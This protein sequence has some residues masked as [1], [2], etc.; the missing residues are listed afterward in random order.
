MAT[1]RPDTALH[2]S[3]EQWVQVLRIDWLL[4]K[5]HQANP[6]RKPWCEIMVAIWGVITIAA[7]VRDLKS[8]SD[9]SANEYER[10]L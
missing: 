4:A 3:V 9:H 2:G 8:D 7:P 1:F 5:A 10:G 6:S